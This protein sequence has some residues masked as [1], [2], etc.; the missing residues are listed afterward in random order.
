LAL[1]LAPA[2]AHLDPQL[3]IDLGASQALDLR[4]GCR[5]DFAKHLALATYNYALLGIPLDENVGPHVGQGVG[6]GLELLHDDRHRVGDLL[7]SHAQHLLTDQLGGDLALGLVG[8]LVA[9]IIIS[10]MSWIISSINGFI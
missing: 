1:I 5:T 8:N 3:Q 4:S 10:L 6:T 2:F 7:A 9:R